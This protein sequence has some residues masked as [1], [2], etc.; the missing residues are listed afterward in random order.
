MSKVKEELIKEQEKE[1]T[2]FFW[3][4]VVAIVSLLQGGSILYYQE[5]FTERF[6]AYFLGINEDVFGF[7]LVFFAV[8]KLLG[9]IADSFKM[10]SIGIVGLSIIWGMLTVI[11]VM[12]S[13]GIGYPSTAYLSNGFVLV[14]CLRISYKHKGAS[15]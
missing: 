14:A 15:R 6:D 9:I 10:R 5:I 11:A 2:S 8:V 13:F 1:R 12:F 4:K 3:G 7:L